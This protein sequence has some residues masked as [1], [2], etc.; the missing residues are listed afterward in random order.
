MSAGMAGTDRGGKAPARPRKRGKHLFDDR[1]F[2][3]LADEQPCS[4][5]LSRSWRNRA[6]GRLPT[7]NSPTW[8]K[9]WRRWVSSVT[10]RAPAPFQAHFTLESTPLLTFHWKRLEG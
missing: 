5:L 3:R 1:R 6:S 4:F 7:R 10:I 9:V 8:A 2:D